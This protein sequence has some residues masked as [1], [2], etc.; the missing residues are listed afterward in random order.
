MANNKVAGLSVGVCFLFAVFM[1]HAV[2]EAPRHIVFA[3][4]TQYPWTDKT[5]SREPES[6]EEFTTRSKWLVES[7]LASIADFRN[8]HG[9]QATVPLMI[10]GDITA[11]GHGWQRD[12]MASALNK[13]FGTDY[14]YGLGNHDYENNVDD[15]FSNS[16][17]AGSIVEFKEHHQGKVDSFDLTITGSAVNKLY[18]GSLAYSKTIG[19]VHLVQLNNE[20]TYSTKISSVWNPTTFD[21]TSALDWL[22]TDL[23]L[24]RVAGYAII[25]NMHK[26]HEMMGDASQRKR[27]IE[28]IDK[29]QVTAIFAGHLH[30][31]GGYGFWKGSASMFLS[32][33]PSQQTYLIASFSEDRKQL[34]VYLVKNNR[35]QDRTLIETIPVKSIWASRP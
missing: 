30:R 19:D 27:F 7:Q 28:M 12:Y 4:D 34:Q 20:P 22:E 24:A 25:I 21:I 14:L 13:H 17:A 23:R 26:P 18:S 32:G 33:A 15:C 3:S 8:H 5:D 6:S 31:E 10:N 16:C 1:A 2:A 11:F 35:W 9:S 29:Y